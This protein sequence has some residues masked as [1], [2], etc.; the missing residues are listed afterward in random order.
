[1]SF[2]TTVI[3]DY[4]DINYDLVSLLPAM[5]SASL[6]DLPNELLY[7]IISLLEQKDL[8]MLCSAIRELRPLVYS[9]LNLTVETVLF[10]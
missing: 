2:V 3:T 5:H 7:K 4:K 10:N 1:M 6:T 8:E 9:L